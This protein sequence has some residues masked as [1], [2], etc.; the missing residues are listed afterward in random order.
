MSVIDIIITTWIKSYKII[1]EQLWIAN[2]TIA[3]VKL[4]N[5]EIKFLFLDIKPIKMDKMSQIEW[6]H[7]KV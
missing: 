1:S 6:T 4:K 3:R 7:K 5:V 2:T